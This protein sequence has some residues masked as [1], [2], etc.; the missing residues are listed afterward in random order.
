MG[1]AWS[2]DRYG[3]LY[4]PDGV[5]GGGGADDADALAGVA[6]L[7]VWTVAYPFADEFANEEAAADGA[8][9][10]AAATVVGRFAS[11]SDVL[12]DVFDLCVAT[13]RR[14]SLD[15]F[16]DSN[17]RERLPYEGDGFI[18]AAAWRAVAGEVG[19][20]R[21][22]P[23]RRRRRRAARSF[24]RPRARGMSLHRARGRS[25]V[26]GGS[27][28]AVARSRGGLRSGRFRATRRRTTR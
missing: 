4:D 2:I 20:F 27:A 15:T 5:L 28:R 7:S 9:A 6:N 25:R 10:A 11:S 23:R 14:T 26:H 18:T 17:T 12:N 1:A 21:C 19:R 8:A 3:E 13:L 22:R 16:T 24:G